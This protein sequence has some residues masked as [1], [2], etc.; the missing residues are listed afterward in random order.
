MADKEEIVRRGSRDSFIDPEWADSAE[1]A[2]SADS[3]EL[4]D[5]P[6]SSHSDQL[7]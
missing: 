5:S 6:D 4:P 1:R 2:G 7:P 3:L